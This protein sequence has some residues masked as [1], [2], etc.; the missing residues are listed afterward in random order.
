MKDMANDKIHEFWDA[1]EDVTDGMLGLKG[2][3]LIPMA[4]KV[5]DDAEDG[6]IWFITAAGT[7]LHKAIAGGAQEARFVVAERNEGIWADIEGTLAAENDA[8]VLDEIWSAAAAAWFD[9][10]REDDD[11]R[12]MSFTPRTAEVTLTDDNPLRFFY[13]IAKARVT[14]EKPDFGGW[15]GKLTF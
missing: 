15:Q 6:K 9:E 7:D 1:L 2:D 4:P 14:D 5:R 8:S 11:V 10:G 3:A 12:L 13:E